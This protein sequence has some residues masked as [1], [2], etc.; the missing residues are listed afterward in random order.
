MYW[1][2]VGVS[3]LRLVFIAF[4]GY[5][6][7]LITGEDIYEKPEEFIPERWYSRPTMV[8]EKSA[9]APF[10]TGTSLICVTHDLQ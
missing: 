4:L 10:S 2:E 3:L 5:F 1:E 8:K 7:T 6:L 9:F